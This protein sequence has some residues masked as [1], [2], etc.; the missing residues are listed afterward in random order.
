MTFDNPNVEPKPLNFAEIKALDVVMHDVADGA[1]PIGSNIFTRLYNRGRARHIT[2]END[3]I[4][5]A[6]EDAEVVSLQ[7]GKGGK[8][9]AELSIAPKTL[10]F[11]SEAAKTAIE[12]WS[13]DQGIDPETQATIRVLKGF[14]HT[15]EPPEAQ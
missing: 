14:L 10:K 1:F 2:R 15:I 12:H 6:F 11:V 3:A 5:R 9:T 8:A 13:A 4:F 7:V